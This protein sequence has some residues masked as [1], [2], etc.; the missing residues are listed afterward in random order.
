MASGRLRLQHRSTL[1]QH[2][3]HTLEDLLGDPVLLQQMAEVKI[4]SFVG[5][6]LPKFIHAIKRASQ[7]TVIARSDLL[8]EAIQSYPD[9]SPVLDCLE[10]MRN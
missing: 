4:R 2:L 6:Q 1:T 10:E 3:V 7:L 5:D 9:K 8:A